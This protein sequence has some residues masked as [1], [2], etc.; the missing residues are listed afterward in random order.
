MAHKNI[1]MKKREG[2]QWDNLY[3]ITLDSNVFDTKGVPLSQKLAN[4]D[5]K[6]QNVVTQLTQIENKF[7]S[8]WINVKHPPAPLKPAI[9][10]GVTDDT[11]AIQ[12]IINNMESGTVFIP[13]GNYKI[14]S[15]G[16]IINKSNIRLMGE[17]SSSLLFSEEYTHVIQV[18]GQDVN[19]RIENVS[20][21]NL[22]VKGR[23]GTSN[24]KPSNIWTGPTGIE[25]M[26]ADNIV[27]K[28]CIV[29]Q[30]A[31]D[32]IGIPQAAKNIT[33]QDCIVFDC[34]DDGIN[35]GG[36]SEVNHRVENVII[37]GNNVYNIENAG[38]HHSGNLYGARTIKNKVWN[39]KNAV[40]FT[41]AYN[42]Y[43]ADNELIGGSASV[44]DCKSEGANNIIHNNIVVGGTGGSGILVRD[45]ATNYTITA[46]KVRDVVDVGISI[47]GT[48]GGVNQI[49]D[50]EVINAGNHGIN[51]RKGVAIVQGNYVSGITTTGIIM[52]G[53]SPFSRISENTIHNVGGNGIYLD[54]GSKSI[55]SSNIIKEAGLFGVSLA[56]TTSNC[57]IANNIIN[58]ASSAINDGGTSNEKVN[59]KAV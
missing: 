19:N 48:G 59:N 26:Y 40:D 22:R 53:V 10:D 16:I 38:I 12:S 51:V 42:V 18:R 56:Q 50:N 11:A 15:P 39:C 21:V 43:V 2:S 37:E 25:I 20:I 49:R 30:H 31:Y 35:P 36:D 58:A 52:V 45:N 32:G 41:N 3:P 44:I 13:A 6:H 24:A 28:N 29:H 17:G 1:Q 54:N 8:E 9:G 33:I 14:S 5:E 57:L 23:T 7:N 27:V 47:I 4:I 46:N 55:I 34:L